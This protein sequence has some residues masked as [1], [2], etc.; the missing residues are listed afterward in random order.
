MELW[1]QFSK[2]ELVT[3]LERLRKK[4]PSFKYSLDINGKP[5]I[6]I[7]Q[8]KFDTPAKAIGFIRS[9]NVTNVD[10]FDGA[11]PAYKQPMVGGQMFVG[12]NQLA[13]ELQKKGISF[14]RIGINNKGRSK[15]QAEKAIEV[16]GGDNPNALIWS[17]KDTTTGLMFYEKGKPGK[18]LTR[19]KI[20][21]I[22]EEL[23][24]VFDEKSKTIKRLSALTN[25]YQF[26]MSGVNVN[27]NGLF[28]DPTQTERGR[29]FMAE[30]GYTS[31]RGATGYSYRAAKSGAAGLKG[32]VDLAGR[33]GLESMRIYQDKGKMQL[34][35][36][37]VKSVEENYRKLYGVS[38]RFADI[39]KSELLEV[40]RYI[41]TQKAA[42]KTVDGAVF[43]S[44][45]LA[46]NVQTAMLDQANALRESLDDAVKKG[47]L[48]ITDP[49]YMNGIKNVEKIRRNVEKLNRS[50][51]HGG[52]FNVRIMNYLNIADEFLG[53][54]VKNLIG[55]VKGDITIIGE[56]GGKGLQNW[57]KQ[58]LDYVS[59]YGGQIKVVDGQLVNAAGKTLSPEEIQFIA[60]MSSET[61]EFSTISGSQA[62]RM[63]GRFSLETV[64]VNDRVF[65]DS[66]MLYA[67]PELFD[68]SAIRV[69]NLRDVAEKIEYL[70]S[71]AIL[72]EYNAYKLDL[73][74]GIKTQRPE[75]IL[76]ALLEAADSE[77]DDQGR[78]SAKQML[79]LLDEGIGPKQNPLFAQQFLSAVKEYSSGK[80]GLPKLLVPLVQKAHVGT[81]LSK[82]NDVRRG[83]LSYSEGK[84]FRLH[85]WDYARYSKSFGGFDLDDTLSA[86]MAWDR[87]SDSLL[88]VTKRT[89]G[90]RGEL[91]VLNVDLNDQ[92]TDKVLEKAA[93]S[94]LAAKAHMD[95]IR[96]TEAR[97]KSVAGVMRDAN[98][99]IYK[100]TGDVL[101]QN[102][103]SM[104]DF[105]ISSLSA[106][107]LTD[108]QRIFKSFIDSG[109]GLSRSETLDILPAGGG[110]GIQDLK[111]LEQELLSL[112]LGGER[113]SIIK[114]I[115]EEGGRSFSREEIKKLTRRSIDVGGEREA[116][117]GLGKYTTLQDKILEQVAK[118]TTVTK[119]TFG[120]LLTESL[121]ASS[122]NQAI[123]ERFANFRMV[124]DSALST[125]VIEGGK[126]ARLATEKMIELLLQ[127]EVIDSIT[128]DGGKY[129]D[130][131]SKL[132]DKGI[133]SLADAMVNDGVRIDRAMIENEFGESK[134]SAQW[135]DQISRRI[136]ETTGSKTASINDYL[137][138][139]RYSEL[140]KQSRYTVDLIEREF[141]NASKSLGLVKRLEGELF[142]LDIEKEADEILEMS[143]AAFKAY[144]PFEGLDLDDLK[145]KQL[146]FEDLG[147]EDEASIVKA[148]A[149]EARREFSR[150]L[151]ERGY[152]SEVDD[153]VEMSERGRRVVGSLMQRRGL[154][155][156]PAVGDEVVPGLLGGEL[157]DVFHTT[158]SWF[159]NLS[160][161]KSGQVPATQDMSGMAT[162]VREQVIPNERPQEVARAIEGMEEVVPG[163]AAQGR[164]RAARSVSGDVASAA[165]AASKPKRINLSS[166]KELFE[167]KTF[168]RG[169]IAI[170][171]LVAFSAV[172]QKV[173]DRTPED[174]SGPPLLP[175]GSFYSGQKTSGQEINPISQQSGQS[176]VTY[177]VRATGDFNSEEFSNSMSNLTG[178]DVKTSDYKTR[179]Y[180]R[181][182]SP[183]EEAINGSFR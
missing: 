150:Q 79:S 10:T 31:V 145:R 151:M 80:S 122:K 178:A 54:D 107:E 174:L 69:A 67:D 21:E 51:T 179:G 29:R 19:S 167:H 157:S 91:A 99:D 153:G 118:D 166:M 130:I 103:E 138:T 61:M 53:Q 117:K 32:F 108:E 106:D 123:L 160:N 60:P 88:S 97:I 3:N 165:R 126:E 20:F 18:P 171:G 154:G 180:Q 83:F 141:R 133:N 24:F 175:G 16:F 28:F 35:E 144:D 11:L 26:G 121:E 112:R 71:D 14:D 170:G 57:N 132:T 44:A 139:G 47:A 43:G 68:S 38:K 173:K 129:A 113:K 89:P 102:L 142:D 147:L 27:I 127:E 13:D 84:G 86:H 22:L 75:G 120:D 109:T 128:Q 65:V 30:G 40:G 131:V 4:Y 105:D 163:R 6:M 149:L 56:E 37:L 81:S 155:S 93:K 124:F 168:R 96:L 90:A 59:G 72:E 104:K 50:I 101:S 64:G 82:T 7:G 182:R 98:R 114:G 85:D 146:F 100:T 1:E 148:R 2:K 74:L 46:R 9:L 41:E 73:E 177:R 23:G 52:V 33:E 169:S 95:A 25:E 110:V 159:N 94:N 48:S 164:A 55:Q 8:Q 135:V 152:L 62:Q 87:G 70:K 34:D 66:Q 12:L 140:M 134:L 156:L 45:Q 92:L 36:S 162:F 125:T 76:G 115:V 42:L 49:D 136:Q 116:L 111:Q 143:K 181:K 15:E 63:G 183:I 17:R 5:T 39:D 58:L 77:V 161:A 119:K 176:G 158:L 78:R 172:Y 137:I